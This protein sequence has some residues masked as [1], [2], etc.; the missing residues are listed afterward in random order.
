[1]FCSEDDQSLI[2]L[3]DLQP[4]PTQVGCGSV[5]FS[6]FPLEPEVEDDD[7]ADETP[8]TIDLTPCQT[9]T[10]DICTPRS[11]NKSLTLWHRSTTIEPLDS[12]LFRVQ[13]TLDAF[14]SYRS[15]E[16]ICFVSRVWAP[17][18][19]PLAYHGFALSKQQISSKCVQ[20]LDVEESYWILVVDM[21]C[22]GSAVGP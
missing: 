1:M 9:S 13:T 7:R 6:A 16:F 14:S 20:H 21:G 8:M 10:F 12:P 15:S 17:E 2:E 5:E 19:G 4:T 18:Y 11:G 22:V 3:P